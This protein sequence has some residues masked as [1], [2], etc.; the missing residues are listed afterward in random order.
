MKKK[1]YKGKCSKRTVDK[2]V[3]V[4][5]SFDIL[6]SRACDMLAEDEDIIEFRTNVPMDGLDYTS[7]IVAA[8]E[9]GSLIVYECCRQHILKRPT[10]A[11]LLEQSRQYWLNHNVKEKDWR[12]VVDAEKSTDKE[13]Q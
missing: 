2:C 11:K 1:N 5:K 8:R 3:G 9:D 4:C 10:M 12:L 6:Q 7:D 13:K